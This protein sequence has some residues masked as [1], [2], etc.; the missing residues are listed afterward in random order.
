VISEWRDLQEP[1]EPGDR[2]QAALFFCPIFRVI[3]DVQWLR[4]GFQTR[5]ARVRF[6]PSVLSGIHGYRHEQLTTAHLSQLPAVG[7]WP[8]RLRWSEEIGG[9]S[10][11]SWTRRPQDACYRPSGRHKRALRR[12]SAV[13]PAQ[14][15]ERPW[16]NWTEHR[17]TKPGGAGSSPAGRAVSEAEAGD[18]PGRG[19]GGSG[20][21]SRRTPS[22]TACSH[23]VAV[24]ARLWPNW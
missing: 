17:P 10:P 23:T 1:S 20:F 11:P 9:S 13:H 3:A 14:G 5:V 6:P 4:T 7:R 21:E 16:L 2:Q 12:K 8:G 24:P 18:A 22:S 15:T 19:P